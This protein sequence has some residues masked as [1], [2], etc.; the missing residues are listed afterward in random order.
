MRFACSIC[1]QKYER[2]EP[3]VALDDNMSPLCKHHADKN[4]QL[5]QRGA[6]SQAMR[7]ISLGWESSGPSDSE[8]DAAD[9]DEKVA[10]KRQR[11]L[12]KK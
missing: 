3:G 10:P 12:E 1:K 5:R 9:E 7:N 6:A 2:I 8:S 11:T 4:E